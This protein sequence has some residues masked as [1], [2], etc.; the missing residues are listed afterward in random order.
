M[1]PIVSI[2]IP[3]YNAEKWITAT[4][5]SA[6]AQDWANK[7]II[8]VDDGSSDGTLSIAKQFESKSLKVISQE[9]R[10]ASAAR[11]R[12]FQHA[13]G[14]YIQWL[15][16]D[17]VLAPN[18]LSEQM[19]VV[20]RAQKNLILYSGPHGTFYWRPEKAKFVPNALWRDVSPVG[21]LIT[22]F[23]ENLWML[24]AGWLV[25]R[26]LTEKAGPWDERLSLDDDG[27]YFARVVA[28]SESI[29]FV[30]E[31][32]CYYRQS[33][34]NQL[35]RSNTQKASES[36][37]RS[38]RLSILHLM[39]LEESERT[40]KASLIYIHT[41]LPY[42]YPE[43]TEFLNML[44]GIAFDLGGELI[45]PR[46][47]LKAL[48]LQRAVGPRYARKLLTAIR[49][50]RLALAVKWDEAMYTIDHGR[51]KTRPC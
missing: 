43:K 11:N 34:F 44:S 18:K 19:K 30:P 37:L 36:L 6:L 1:A 50:A 4:I 10:G 39:S 12:A 20:N 26:T 27:E 41:I 46:L 38:V 2:L 51:E 28:T 24:P 22:K 13:Q 42:F 31:A 3:A 47:E 33:G 32:R 40:R 49:K 29:K 25:S 8:I 15:D 21:W 17:D 14:E 23:C 7:E 35:S 48:I 16:A 45:P 5:C 9:N